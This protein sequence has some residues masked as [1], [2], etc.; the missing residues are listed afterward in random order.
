MCNVKTTLFVLEIYLTI[1]SFQT[2]TTVW[3]F[4]SENWYAFYGSTWRYFVSG[5]VEVWEICTICKRKVTVPRFSFGTKSL[6]SAFCVWG[7]Q[8]AFEWVLNVYD[9]DGNIWTQWVLYSYRDHPA[10]L[11]TCRASNGSSLDLTPLVGSPGS[12]PSPPLGKCPLCISWHASCL[13]NARL[14]ASLCLSLP[15]DLCRCFC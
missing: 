10:A 14:G 3:L 12:L 1:I 6:Q 5:S 13:A 11:Q 2:L 9:D 7:L 15:L 4:W 8:M